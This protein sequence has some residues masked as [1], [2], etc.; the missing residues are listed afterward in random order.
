M[1]SKMNVPERYEFVGL[2][3]IGSISYFDNVDYRM[4]DL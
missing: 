3:L 4:K 1:R 2:R